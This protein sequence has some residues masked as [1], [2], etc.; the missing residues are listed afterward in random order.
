MRIKLWGTVN[1]TVDIT[2]TIAPDYEPEILTWKAEVEAVGGTVNSAISAIDTYIKAC[3]SGGIWT[4]L[5]AS[6]SLIMPYATDTF[7]GLFVPLVK[8]SGVSPT[9]YVFT[10]SDYSLSTG[11]V[12]GVGNTTKYVDLGYSPAAWLS[13]GNA[14]ISVYL[15]TD[16]DGADANSLY[17]AEVSG[18]NASLIR[19]GLSGVKLSNFSNQ[20]IFDAWNVQD[21][22]RT[23]ATAASALG[24]N[25]GI[26]IAATDG[27]ILVNGVQIGS[28]NTF[29]AARALPIPTLYEFGNNYNGTLEYP[30]RRPHSYLYVGPALTVAEEVIHY[31]AV[32]ALQTALGRAV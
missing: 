8:P 26:R 15:R 21:S 30:G 28:T 29:N 4:K 27:R 16:A 31:N 11:L 17:P 14:Q 20:S 25:S 5:G 32:Q 2:A 7:A 3:K 24:L 6:N 19:L 22:S 10:G 9:S 1:F 12:P 18:T 13:S 23:I